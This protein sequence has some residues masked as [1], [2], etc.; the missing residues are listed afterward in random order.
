M[1]REREEMAEYGKVE[2]GSDIEEKREANNME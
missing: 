1:V 2:K